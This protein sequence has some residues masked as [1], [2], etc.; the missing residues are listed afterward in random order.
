MLLSYSSMYRS[1]GRIFLGITSIHLTEVE[2]AVHLAS[3]RARG[4]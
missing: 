3:R 2:L 1:S 4:F